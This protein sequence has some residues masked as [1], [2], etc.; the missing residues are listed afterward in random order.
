MLQYLAYVDLCIH[1]LILDGHT[2]LIQ[3][4][5]ETRLGVLLLACSSVYVRPIP[6]RNLAYGVLS[7]I[8]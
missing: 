2:G 5:R 1:D 3:Q 4:E 7:R 6:A 8:Q